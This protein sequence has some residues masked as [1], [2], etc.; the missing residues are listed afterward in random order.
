MTTFAVLFG[1]LTTG[2]VISAAALLRR[3]NRTTE[4][5]DGLRTEQ[6]HRRYAHDAR[7][8]YRVPFVDG[9]FPGG[10]GPRRH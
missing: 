3:R 5:A 1:L 7:Q 8:T 9:S 2:A 10:Q 4:N 6:E